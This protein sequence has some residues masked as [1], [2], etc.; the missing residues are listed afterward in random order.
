MNIWYHTR[1]GKPIQY[2]A[3]QSNRIEC[4]TIQDYTRQ[5]N[6]HSVKTKQDETI[7]DNRM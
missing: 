1:P 6:A 3:V 5:D 4:K 2:N 7:E